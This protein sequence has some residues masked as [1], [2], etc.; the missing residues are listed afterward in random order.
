V[1]IDAI[2]PTVKTQLQEFEKAFAEI[3]RSQVPL[4]DKIVQYISELKGKRLRPALVFLS[5]QLHGILTDKAMD[6]AVVVELLHTATLIH[7][8][9]VDNSVLRRGHPTVNSL[10]DNRISILVGDLLFSRTLTAVLNLKSQ[11]ALSILSECAN[12]ITEG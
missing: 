11:E 2:T 5:A 9:V 3:L 6:A 10:W 12:R 4:A 8:D 1:N 7:D